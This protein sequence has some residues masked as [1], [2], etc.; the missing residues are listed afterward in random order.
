MH[1]HPTF[2]KLIHALFLHSEM[3]DPHNNSNAS[4]FLMFPS[5]V[6]QPHGSADQTFHSSATKQHIPLLHSLRREQTDFRKLS[7]NLDRLPKDT[8]KPRKT[9]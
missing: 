1:C 5:S 9:K 2:I 8:K 4:L 7:S 3:P 6:E